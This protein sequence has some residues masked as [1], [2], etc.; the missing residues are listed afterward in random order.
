MLFRSVQLSD[1]WHAAIHRELESAINEKHG[2]GQSD[3]HFARGSEWPLVLQEPLTLENYKFTELPNVAALIQ[4]GRLMQHCVGSYGEKCA[5][6]NT[7]IFSVADQGDMKLATLE[8]AICEET[9]RISLVSHKGIR[10]AN[11]SEECQ[12][13]ALAFVNHLNAEDFAICIKTRQCFQKS[14]R[15]ISAEISQVKMAQKN[16]CQRMTQR[17]AWQCCFG[18]A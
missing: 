5:H 7:L 12:E 2:T 14:R 1:N 9:G 3:L 18:A 13:A 15:A 6:G 10:N 17:V 11:P 8:L 4:E 16:N